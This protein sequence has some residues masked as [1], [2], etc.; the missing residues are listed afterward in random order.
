MVSAPPDVEA[1]LRKHEAD[2]TTDS[3]DYVNACMVFYQRHV[4]RLDPWPAGVTA[5]FAKID[6]DP[7]S[8][9]QQWRHDDEQV[10]YPTWELI[11]KN[12]ERLKAKKPRRKSPKRPARARRSSSSRS[13]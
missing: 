7:H 1:T 8:L 9:M 11:Q 6:E 4:C 5:G 3:A 13:W 2:G 10:A 12:Y